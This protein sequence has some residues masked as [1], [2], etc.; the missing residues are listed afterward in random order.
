MLSKFYKKVS[1]S[2]IIPTY[3]RNKNLKIIVKNLIQQSPKNVKIEI[4]TISN[5]KNNLSN[6]FKKLNKKYVQIK[7]IYIKKNSNSAKR[8]KGIKIAK[9]ENLILID[10]DCLPARNF[11]INY[12]RLFKQTTD[13]EI[14]CGTVKYLKHKI[15]N[16]NFIRYRQSRHFIKKGYSLI[17]TNNLN[18][19]NIVTMNMGV[20][21]SKLFKNTKYFNEQFGGYGFEDYEFGF[22][23]IRNGFRFI[24]SNPTIYHLD[25]RNYQSY[26]NKIYFLS[27][28]SVK[29]LKKTNY[30]SWKS[31]IYF[32][33][34]NN[35]LI[36][37]FLKIKFIHPLIRITEKFIVFI[38]KNIFLYL[39]KLYRFGIFLSYCR[40][41][42]D[43]KVIKRNKNYDWY[44]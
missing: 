41:Y 26:L 14:L 32:K 31:T 29:I 37:L 19:S 44:K 12:L 42:Y 30:N 7:S 25:D 23:L 9:G 13:K 4:I 24:K 8:N 17:K 33:I 38:E 35:L 3:K 1:L 40:G 22:R 18:P 5:T 36:N 10:D 21:N 6:H 15:N 43:R 2:I 39:P 34:E 16:E 20:K 27:K 11:I 28:Y